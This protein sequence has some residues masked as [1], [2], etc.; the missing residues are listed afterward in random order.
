MCIASPA[1]QG[2]DVALLQSVRPLLDALQQRAREP[3]GSTGHPRAIAPR[4]VRV[5]WCEHED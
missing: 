2:G 1:G 4:R 3:I 5:T